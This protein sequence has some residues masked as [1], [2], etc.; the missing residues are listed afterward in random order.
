MPRVY[1]SSSF[2]ERAD[3]SLVLLIRDCP[4]V[5]CLLIRERVSTATLLIIAS[6]AKN[7]KTLHVRRNAIIK[8]CGWP[9][10]AHWTDDFYVWLK[11]CSQDYDTVEHEISQ[12]LQTNWTML[13]DK[14]Y[15]RIE[16]E[17]KS[18]SI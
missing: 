15:R 4:N 1:T 18:L 8:R 16:I 3:C 11:K 14:D 10:A 6:E 13:S 5:R 17:Y 12:I 9:K 2:H 7:L